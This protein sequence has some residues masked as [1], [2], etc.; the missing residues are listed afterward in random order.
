MGPS[1]HGGDLLARRATAASLRRK[2]FEGER[3][4]IQRAA[5]DDLAL[6]QSCCV[7]GRE[8]L[9]LEIRDLPAQAR[10]HVICGQREVEQDAPHALA[11]VG[12]RGSFIRRQRGLREAAAMA[13]SA[14]FEMAGLDHRAHI[15]HAAGIRNAAE[16]RQQGSASGADEA[17]KS[18]RS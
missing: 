1:V 7:P 16:H 17:M 14:C 18:R 8:F 5:I 3:L 4:E 6:E 9:G 13:A 12:E 2:R 11:L 10:L 15:R